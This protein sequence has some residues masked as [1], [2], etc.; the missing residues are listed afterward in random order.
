M[1]VLQLV[2]KGKITLDQPVDEILP[3]LADPEI[4]EGWNDDGSP[5]LRK[6]TRRIEV[7]HLLTHTSGLGYSFLS[8][9]TTRWFAH[10]KIDQKDIQGDVV[11]G[12]SS[13]LLFEPGSKWMY[14][15]GLDWAGILVARVSG[16]TELQEY[17]RKNLWTPLGIRG[18][19][20]AFRKRDLGLDDAD[21]GETWVHASLRKQGDAS[22]VPLE[23]GWRDF[24]PKDCLGGGGIMA[25]PEAY[26]KVLGSLLRND[27]VILKR[28]T[29]D[30]FMLQPM[31]VQGKI[32][33][34]AYEGLIGVLDSMV[35]ARMLTGGLPLPKEEGCHEYQYG[36]LG[37]LSREKGQ[38]GGEQEQ[39]QWTLSWGGL[40]NL[41]WHVDREE[42]VAGM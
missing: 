16:E 9:E 41:F 38:N 37:L 2:E 39:K 7:R 28:E 14:S 40:P 24:N 31:L 25:S 26:L 8:E 30:E 22:L 33:T 20:M 35:G 3:E 29:L 5:V 42:G 34:G 12:Y 27:G 15:P 32:G 36:L 10:K 17:M 21:M 13:P 4:L 11:R 1:C 18:G 6:A 23:E 19:E